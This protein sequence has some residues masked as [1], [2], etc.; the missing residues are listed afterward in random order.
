M[1]R[2]AVVSGLRALLPRTRRLAGPVTEKYRTTIQVT[3]IAVSIAIF[4]LWTNPEL[5][6]VLTLAAMAATVLI[7]L[8]ALRARPNSPSARAQ[9][10][11]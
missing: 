6:L 4:A 9:P 11:E 7:V 8:E 2:L 1:A 5:A 3:V 10:L